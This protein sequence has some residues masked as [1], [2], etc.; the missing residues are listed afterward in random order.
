MYIFLCPSKGWRGRVFRGCD[1]GAIAPA[2]KG[3][4]VDFYNILA[5]LDTGASLVSNVLAI[6]SQG[7]GLVLTYF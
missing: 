3:N 4:T 2:P 5:L 7:L 6:V 1:G